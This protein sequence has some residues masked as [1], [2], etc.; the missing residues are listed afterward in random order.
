MKTDAI[1]LHQDFFTFHTF[2]ILSLTFLIALSGFAPAQHI[3]GSYTT[4]APGASLFFLNPGYINP[5]LGSGVIGMQSNP[6]GLRSIATRKFSVA[7]ATSQSSN[8]HFT[9]Q[10]I[11]S[12]SVYLP[13]SV[14]ADIKMK[15]PGGM[16]A[17]G[18]AQQQGAWTWGVS[19]LQARKGG[20]TLDFNGLLDIDT[21][22]D[23]DQPITKEMVPDLP[24][25]EI[26]VTW[27]ID[28][29]LSLALRSRPAELYLSI[30]PI[31]AAVAVEKG[32]F[33]L[34]AGLTYFHI[35]SSDNVG[36]FS[37]D[38]QGNA[39]ISG[40]PFGV[41][42]A[43]GRPWLGAIGADI[44]FADEPIAANYKFQISGH[45]FA[46]SFGGVMN[47]GIF[48][49]GANASHGFK[50]DINGSYDIS[51]IVTSGLPEASTLSDVELEFTNSPVLSGH[52]KM[53]LKNFA[54]DTLSWSND[55]I[56]KMGGYNSLSLGI[57]FLGIGAFVG[58]EV[59]QITPDFLST[60]MGAYIDWPLPWLPIRVNAG[61]IYRS[62]SFMPE[63]STVAPYRITTHIGGGV[64][65]KFPFD[66]WFNLGEQPAWLR[67]GVRSSLASVAVDVIEKQALDPENRSLPNVFENIAMSIGLE[68]PF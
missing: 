12:S 3:T 22:F 5:A 49:V 47:W 37:A 40:S 38:I 21:N 17:I 55:G 25:D 36:H 64:A 35:S 43:T 28:A 56:L 57:Y 65:M 42:P 27:N 29:Q 67:L 19:M 32:I 41:D 50:A 34:G 9:F 53:D 11:D 51:T 10:L 48:S 14:D 44:S 18:Y 62:D 68:F 46:L 13:F 16:G 23:I 59:P 26:P 1:S 60:Y 54:K 45:R 30:L 63:E 52:A 24:V 20:I 15:E 33:A 4:S 8:S 39:A 66:R 31:E 58:A 6:A 2:L 61:V 7:F